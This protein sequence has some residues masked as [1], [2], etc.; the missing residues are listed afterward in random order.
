MRFSQFTILIS[1]PLAA[2]VA[3]TAAPERCVFDGKAP[4]DRGQ[5]TAAKLDQAGDVT[6]AFIAAMT[7]SCWVT[8]KDQTK[9]GGYLAEHGWEL[10][11]DLIEPN[12]SG[13]LAYV[14]HHK[15]SGDLIV[16]FRGTG[17]KGLKNVGNLV[18]NIG[19]DANARPKKITWLPTKAGGAWKRLGARALAT[20][21]AIKVHAGFTNQYSKFAATI[22]SAVKDALAAKRVTRII[23]SGFSLGAALA[24]HCGLHMTLRFDTPVAVLVGASPRVGSPQFQTAYDR[25]VPAIVRVMLERDPVP[26]MPGLLLRKAYEHVGRLLPLYD[27]KDD[28]SRA[29]LHGRPLDAKALGD[30]QSFLG[31]L[32]GAVK[33]FARYHNYL[34]YKETVRAYLKLCESELKCTGDQLFRWGNAERNAK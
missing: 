24:T 25:Q 7:H 27:T 8:Q 22:E 21:K 13:G 14:A 30:A 3:Y 10:A 23:C 28:K 26:Q 4:E 2:R 5:F 31:T 11:R 20:W 15:E 19:A 32:K 9:I 34:R 12:G 6:R 18:A 29:A 1:V 17:A 33:K 16:V